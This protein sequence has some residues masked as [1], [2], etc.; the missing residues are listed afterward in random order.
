MTELILA[1]GKG[2]YWV[3][4]GTDPRTGKVVRHEGHAPTRGEAKAGL[5]EFKLLQAEERAKAAALQHQA[6]KAA[7][8]DA[9]KATGDYQQRRE[10]LRDFEKKQDAEH[11][12]AYEAA[13]VKHRKA[14]GLR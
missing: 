1:K 13:L 7:R 12:A 9:E 8:R 5:E 11:E 4:H 10:K 14:L 6:E 3:L 2:F